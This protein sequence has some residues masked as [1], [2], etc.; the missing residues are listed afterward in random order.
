[1]RQEGR[2]VE[3]RWEERNVNNDELYKHA[4]SAEADGRNRRRKPCT[5][6]DEEI[7]R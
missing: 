3:I 5:L 6:S 7:N 1:M 4:Q 2:V